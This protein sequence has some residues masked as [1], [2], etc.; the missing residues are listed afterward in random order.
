MTNR[1]FLTA[2][3]T[4]DVAD[5]IKAFAVE[6]IAKLDAKNFKRR[7]TLSKEQVANEE[8]KGNMFRLLEENIGKAM[9][10]SEIAVALEITTQKA[11]AL[12]RQLVA[13]GSCEVCEVKSGKSKVK[14][15][16]VKAE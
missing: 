12:L 5:E 16:S 15:Y 11:S 6:E 7:N 8:L 2:V 10:A 1:E 14:G 3:S 4:A 13:S 9:T